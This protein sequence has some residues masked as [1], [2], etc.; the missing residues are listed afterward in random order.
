MWMLMGSWK[1]PLNSS[2][3][4]WSSAFFAMTA[5][6]GQH[7][8]QQFS[9]LA[10]RVDPA[11]LAFESLLH[12]DGLLRAR[13]EVRDAPFG[14]AEGHGTLVG[15]L[16]RR[17]RVRLSQ[18]LAQ[19]HTHT[20][21]GGSCGN[22]PLSCSPRRRSCSQAPR[23]GNYPGLAAMPG[24]GIRPSSCRARQSSWSC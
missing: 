22:L 23:T 4:S 1:S 20:L 16:R 17:Q 24:S 18:T 6:G 14:L 3:S 8:S 5:N 19:T 2:D 10:F 15:N 7:S 11:A 12:I 21:P 9:P 13:L